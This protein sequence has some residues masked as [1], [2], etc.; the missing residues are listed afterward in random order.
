[1]S[2][3]LTQDQ[4]NEDQARHDIEKLLAKLQKATINQIADGTKFSWVTVKKHLDYLEAIGRVHVEDFKSSKLYFYNGTEKWKKTIHLTSK[5]VLF[6]DTF[7]SPFGKSFVRLK[8]VK[9]RD[10]KWVQHG[11]VMVTAEKLSDLIG[12]L[13][14]VE[15]EIKQY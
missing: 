1:M 3:E 14:K 12:F 5:H 13:Q 6:L 9:N 2:S 11:D 7:R 15:T 4:V 8:E 10:G